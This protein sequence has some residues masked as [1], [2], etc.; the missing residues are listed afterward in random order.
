[1]RRVTPQVLLATRIT[2]SNV[3]LFEADGRRFLVD[4]GHFL[5]RPFLRAFLWRAGIR[6]RGDLAGV[7]LTHRH[8]DHAGNARWLR[9]TFDAPILCHEDDAAILRGEEKPPRLAVGRG[10]LH[11][12]LLCRVED[13]WPAQSPI[14]ETFSDGSWRH[15]LRVV[16]APGHTGGS[17]M[18]H[19][20]GTGTLFSGDVL[21][22]GIG[23]FRFFEYPSLAVAGFSADVERC[24]EAVR[25]FLRELPPT[26]ILCAGHGPP[27]TRQTEDKLRRLIDVR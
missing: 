1:M 5:E 8:S 10:R 19:H 25:A 15:G 22:A 6:R 9:R 20:E 18:L 12:E 14:D 11:E 26:R 13:L 3:W 27:I 4:T 7:L 23:P 24:R 2:V 21:I 16:H 17:V